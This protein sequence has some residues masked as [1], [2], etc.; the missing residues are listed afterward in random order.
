MHQ[1]PKMQSNYCVYKHTTPS[2]KVYIGITKQI[3]QKRWKNGK[4]YELCTAFHRAIEKYGWGNIKHEILHANLTEDEACEKEVEEIKR[5]NS[6]DPRHGYNLTNG[7]EHYTPTE[8]WRTRNSKA[9]IAYYISNPEAKAD[10]SK[11]Q[12]GRRLSESTKAKM[13]ESRK[14]FLSANPSAVFHCGDSFRGKKRSEE[15][16]EKLRIAN[17]R[18]VRCIDTQTVYKS[19]NEAAVSLC[20]CRSSISNNLSG[21][22]K[23][24]GGYKFEYITEATTNE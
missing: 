7:G 4:G 3:P 21:R 20:V 8:E 16:R 10:I 13:S 2:G 14:A 15:N 18:P 1:Q 24:A 5:H 9:H 23:T 19:V 11:R 22:S 17:M 6:A 12:V